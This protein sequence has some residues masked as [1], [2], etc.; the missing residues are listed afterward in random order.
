M[1]KT[2][3]FFFS[4]GTCSL[5]NLRFK[6]IFCIYYLNYSEHH[7]SFFCLDWT[8]WGCSI[9]WQQPQDIP[10]EVICVVPVQPVAGVSRG[11]TSFILRLDRRLSSRH[12]LSVLFPFLLQVIRWR[13]DAVTLIWRAAGTNYGPAVLVQRLSTMC[14][15]LV[16]R[17]TVENQDQEQGNLTYMFDTVTKMCLFL[18]FYL[19]LVWIWSQTSGS[20][21]C[22]H[23]KR[24]VCVCFCNVTYYLDTGHT[25]ESVR[26]RLI[27]CKHHP[28]VGFVISLTVDADCSIAVGDHAVLRPQVWRRSLWHNNSRCLLGAAHF[29]NMIHLR[30]HPDAQI[31][32]SLFTFRTSGLN[33][34]K[35]LSWYF[36]R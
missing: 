26:H 19:I 22:P 13:P 33:E 4:K 17:D 12:W 15:A 9:T 28:P 36:L 8:L 32:I 27:C 5:Y 21:H 10:V 6:T 35:S 31:I 25:G 16:C 24:D 3:F 18:L 14:L 34:L 29:S 1:S 23:R 11:V 7:R 20:S 30:Q 2:I